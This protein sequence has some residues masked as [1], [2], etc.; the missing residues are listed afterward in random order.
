LEQL[1]ESFSQ[2]IE[3]RLVPNTASIGEVKERERE[4]G[5]REIERERERERE[6]GKKRCMD[7]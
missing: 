7:F 6:T 5:K 3:L 2:G 1:K 4:K